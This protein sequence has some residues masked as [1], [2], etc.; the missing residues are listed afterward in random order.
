MKCELCDNIATEKHHLSYFPEITMAVCGFHGNEVHRN[1]R[2]SHLVSYPEGDAQIFY[3]QQKRI[4]SFLFF[5]FR[6]KRK[7]RR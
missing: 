1:P 7:Y 4:S 2:Y 3:D 5:M 6:R